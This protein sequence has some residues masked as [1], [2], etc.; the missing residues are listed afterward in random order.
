[1]RAL[2]PT[3]LSANREMKSI[4]SRTA[5]GV[6]L[7]KLRADN[8]RISKLNDDDFT[9]LME[10]ITSSGTVIFFERDGLVCIIHS[11][12]YHDGMG[13]VLPLYETEESNTSN[14]KI[15]TNTN[16]VS[17]H[18]RCLERLEIPSVPMLHFNRE[19][20]VAI[21]LEPL[22]PTLLELP[23]GL[24][25]LAAELMGYA[26]DVYCGLTESELCRRS[27]KF[28]L[29]TSEERKWV[30]D[31]IDDVSDLYAMVDEGV[32]TRSRGVR[33][34]LHK[35]FWTFAH[36]EARPTELRIESPFA[37]L[38]VLK[39]KLPL[40][41]VKRE[42]PTPRTEQPEP[43]AEESKLVAALTRAAAAKKA[44]DAAQAEYDA[45]I[46]DMLALAGKE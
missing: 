31:A 29:M 32:P 20:P 38:S 6:S 9:E 23:H 30:L 16:T 13:K 36:T 7:E 17:T 19:I 10:Y 37:S 24:R 43:A 46:A 12:K 35:Q 15:K 44:L 5:F 45:A 3:L 33:V 14:I 26:R 2:S 8:D 1:M 25:A 40:E 21:D 4:L 27:S 39:G 11:S 41:P 42:L 28:D 18:E 34:L 22:V